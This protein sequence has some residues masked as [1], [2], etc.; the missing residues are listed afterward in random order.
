MS[1]AGIDQWLS[2]FLT[3]FLFHSYFSVN[4]G[5]VDY[6]FQFSNGGL[7][8]TGAGACNWKNSQQSGIFVRHTASMQTS[9]M[10]TNIRVSIVIGRLLS[11]LRI[12][13]RRLRCTPTSSGLSWATALPS[14]SLAFP[15][16][17]I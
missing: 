13:A 7:P 16:S 10:L 14:T 12:P 5:T 17:E 15:T 9:E 2:F 6:V 4:Y 8:S 1:V 3:V 11:Q